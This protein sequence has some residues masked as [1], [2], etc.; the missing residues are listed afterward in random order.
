MKR[1]LVIIVVALTSLSAGYFIGTIKSNVDEKFQLMDKIITTNDSLNA[2]TKS[3]YSNDQEDFND[4]IYRFISDSLFQFERIKFP[5][6]SQQ[7]DLDIVDSTR[8]EKA[9]WKPV[10]LY[11]GEE[12]K[13]QLYDNFNKEM[14]DTNERLFCWEGIENGINIEYRFSRI[15]GLWYLTE[16][17][18]YSD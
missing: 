6:K 18:D 17:N 12:Y 5:L 3:V 14:R 8:I 1:I 7:W 13:P 9:A 10:R 16:F 2:S 4:F 15:N 11:W